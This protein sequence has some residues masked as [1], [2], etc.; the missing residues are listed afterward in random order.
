MRTLQMVCALAGASGSGPCTVQG[1]VSRR[2][3][4]MHL[5]HP[6]TPSVWCGATRSTRSLHLPSPP[7]GRPPPS[8]PP[9]PCAG[10]STALFDRTTRPLERGDVPGGYCYVVQEY[11]DRPF[12][13]DGRKFELRQ[14]V[15]L[16][17]N[18]AGYTYTTALIRLA[19]LRYSNH[20]RRPRPS[21]PVFVRQCRLQEQTIRLAKTGQPAGHHGLGLAGTIAN[22]PTGEH[23]SPTSLFRPS[24][25]PSRTS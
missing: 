21:P 9:P 12:L 19:S 24:G 15:L 23:T 1:L 2:L 7:D 3:N 6:S 4:G 20:A 8:R 13:L 5:R 17:S 14:Y 25:K 16:C 22:R 11:V 18:G 10:F